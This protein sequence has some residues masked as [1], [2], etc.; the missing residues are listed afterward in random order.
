MNMTKSNTM[1]RKKIWRIPCRFQYTKCISTHNSSNWNSL[2]SLILYFS[3]VL[4]FL[5]RPRNI[6]YNKYILT[7]QYVHILGSMG[8]SATNK[9][10]QQT[11]KKGRK[12]IE[13]N[14][15]SVSFYFASSQLNAIDLKLL[16]ENWWM[17]FAR[18][19]CSF[20]IGWI[21]NAWVQYITWISRYFVKGSWNTV[22]DAP[23]FQWIHTDLYI[24][25]YKNGIGS[26]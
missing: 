6:I 22:L 1:T 10:W 11:G 20:C 9:I 13:N 19:K 7:I 14:I 26:I 12:S 15:F 17:L 24:F 8:N 3:C 25:E 18:Q 2:F 23:E 4:L 16:F 21:G 5:G